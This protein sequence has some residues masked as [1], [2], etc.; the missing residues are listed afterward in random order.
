MFVTNKWLNGLILFTLVLA[1]VIVALSIV[2]ITK[3]PKNEGGFRNTL[4]LG[5]KKAT[6]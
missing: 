2:K 5:K 6:V 3:D 1:A 4:G